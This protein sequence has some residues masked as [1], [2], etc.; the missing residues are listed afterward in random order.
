MSIPR[1]AKFLSK[2]Q[3]HEFLLPM[4]RRLLEDQNDSVKIYAVQSSVDLSSA[5]RDSDILRKTLIPTFRAAAE[6]R[7]SW[8]LRF[9]IAENAANVCEFV[10]KEVVDEDILNLYELLLRDNEPEVR[11]EAVYKVPIVA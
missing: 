3:A 11:S 6:N 2:K 5:L 1:I 4:T 7:Y 10:S 9:A 8:R